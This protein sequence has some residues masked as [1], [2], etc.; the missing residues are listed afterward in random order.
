MSLINDV[1]I[2]MM[3]SDGNI[4]GGV[5]GTQ[6]VPYATDINNFVG[7]GGGLFS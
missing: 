3:D 4:G 5:S 1:G 2:L 7:A 6:F